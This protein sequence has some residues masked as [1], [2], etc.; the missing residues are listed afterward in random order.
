MHRS[1]TVDLDILQDQM[2]GR[3]NIVWKQHLHNFLRQNYEKKSEI[4]VELKK[5]HLRMTRLRV[6]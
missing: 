6:I 4:S 5:Y 1:L 2:F 3:A